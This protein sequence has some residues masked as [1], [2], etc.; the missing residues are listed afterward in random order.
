MERPL[1]PAAD[2]IALGPGDNR[3]AGLEPRQAQPDVGADRQL[4]MGRGA[5]AVGRKIHDL[6]RDAGRAALAQA[7]PT[8]IGTRS[9]TRP[10]GA[11]ASGATDSSPAKKGP[12]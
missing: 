1:E 12:E 6:D 10:F 7:A 3:V 11:G 5:K 2:I 9:D 4:K 8:S